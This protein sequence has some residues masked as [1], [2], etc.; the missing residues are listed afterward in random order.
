MSLHDSQSFASTKIDVE[1][2]RWEKVVA[3]RIVIEGEDRTV[4]NNYPSCR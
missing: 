2:D 1:E 3:M 4:E